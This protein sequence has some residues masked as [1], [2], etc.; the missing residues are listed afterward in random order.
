MGSEI[1]PIRR[2]RLLFALPGFHAVNR[3]AEVA[4]MS[5]AR[6]LRDL[7]YP[8]TLAG[9]G[10]A[11]EGTTY[12][13]VQL[14]CTPRVRFEKFPSLPMFRNDTAY[15][16]FSFGLRLAK[17]FRPHDFDVTFTCNYPF[18]NWVLRRP[19]AWGTKPKH[20]F[21][22]QNGD[23]PAY[24]ARAEYRWFGC[25]G[26]VCTN[27]EY[28][29]R[30]RHRWRCA[31]IPNG[32]TYDRF[33]AAVPARADFG[34]PADAKVV[35]MVSALIASKRVDLG[36]KVI[37]QMPGVQLVVAGDGPMRQELAALAERVAPGRVRFITVASAKMPGLYCSA[38]AVLHLAERESFGNVFVEAIAS[39]VPVVARKSS[40]LM[41]VFGRDEFLS[42]SDSEA[43]IASCLSAAIAQPAELGSWRKERARH[44]DWKNIGRQYSDFIQMVVQ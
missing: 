39:G 6:E 23:W 7:G 10:P 27:P 5:V 12:A 43:E 21:V 3:G 24:A 2:P 33:A 19:I 41:W 22:T 31:L 26:L 9:S 18:S 17:W 8:V 16:D 11:V 42:G 36:I 34:L 38:D 1:E 14:P 13:Y 44:F 15:E 30:N 32:V 29:E 20:V 37:A 4:L 35:L 40:H 25:D 28:L